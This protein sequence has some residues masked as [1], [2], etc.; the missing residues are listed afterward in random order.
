MDSFP[1]NLYKRI[2]ECR[3]VVGS[4]DRQQLMYVSTVINETMRRME[5]GGKHGVELS[6]E[7]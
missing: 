5:N 7:I 6:V 1:D 2:P 3:I 4:T